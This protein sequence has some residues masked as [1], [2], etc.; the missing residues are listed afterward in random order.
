MNTIEWLQSKQLNVAIADNNVGLNISPADKI[1]DSIRNFIVSHKAEIKTELF[2]M[3]ITR[4]LDREPD[5]KLLLKFGWT[6]KNA[7]ICDD[8]NTL[9]LQQEGYITFSPAEIAKVIANEI[10]LTTF[11]AM[12]E[13]KGR[14]NA[15]VCK[16]LG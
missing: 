14:F 12:F 1:T 9:Q 5:K 6:D 16:V 11:E 2:T 7:A 4:I 10:P 8:T 3:S 13:L 15:T